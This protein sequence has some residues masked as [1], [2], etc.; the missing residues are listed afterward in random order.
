[1]LRDYVN[2]KSKTYQWM[3]PQSTALEGRLQTRC[4][5][6]TKRACARCCRLTSAR[7]DASQ[8]ARH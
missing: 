1:M 7:G 6:T 3:L 5:V 8:E 2:R 4:G